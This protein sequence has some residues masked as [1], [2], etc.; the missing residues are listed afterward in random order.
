MHR[1][2]H[3]TVSAGNIISDRKGS[4]S[5]IIQENEQLSAVPNRS[6]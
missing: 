3:K 6:K 1:Q 4:A 5:T 2:E